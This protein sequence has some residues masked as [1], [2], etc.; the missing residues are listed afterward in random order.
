MIGAAA[1]ACRSV[2][3]FVKMG[4]MAYWHGRVRELPSGH[5]AMRTAASAV[6]SV[7]EKPAAPTPPSSGLFRAYISSKSPLLGLNERRCRLC[8]R[9]SGKQRSGLFPAWGGT[10]GVP[11]P[12]PPPPGGGPRPRGAGGGG[13][14]GGPKGPP[15]LG[16]RRAPPG[17]GG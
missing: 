6:G 16:A 17:G 7:Q 14:A 4:R 10:P 2:F 8:R 11:P 1:A 9:R 13:G 12:P 5:W 15:P 3:C